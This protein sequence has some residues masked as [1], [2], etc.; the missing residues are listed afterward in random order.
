[1][2]ASACPDEIGIYDALVNTFNDNFLSRP[3]LTFS[4]TGLGMGS[5]YSIWD[6]VGIFSGGSVHVSKFNQILVWGKITVKGSRNQ[7]HKMT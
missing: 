6:R 3:S 1:M 5:A 4:G 7:W 2:L